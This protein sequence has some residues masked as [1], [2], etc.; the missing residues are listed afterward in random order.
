MLKV[1]ELREIIRLIDQSSISE[2][3]YENRWFE[4]N[5]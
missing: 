2:F 4:D 5:N 3:V 1:Q